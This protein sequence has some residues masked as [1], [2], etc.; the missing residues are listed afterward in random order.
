QITVFGGVII[1]VHHSGPLKKLGVA[2][3]FTPGATTTEIVTWVNANVRQ[4]AQA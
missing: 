1:P 3:L 4:A 2:E